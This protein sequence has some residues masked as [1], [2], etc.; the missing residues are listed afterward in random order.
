[1]KNLNNKHIFITGGS[2]GIGAASASLLAKY[3]AR[4]GVG[5][6]ASEVKAK[7]LVTSLEGEGHFVQSIDVS[8]E[9]SVRAAFAAVL[10]QFNGRLDGLVNSAGCT[11]DKVF[12]RISREDFFKVLNTNLYGSFLCAQA[13][14][15]AMLKARSGSV[16]NVSSIVGKLGNAGQANYAASKGGVES[17]T[18]SLAQEVGRRN[19]RVNCVRPGFIETPMTEK[20]SPEIKKLAADKSCLKRLGT[21]LEVAEAVCFLLSDAASYIT[22]TNLNV[23]GGRLL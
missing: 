9:Q 13:A 4:V 23:C 2:S 8:C 19:I 10:E 22:G 20:L 21:S 7:Q 5:F 16:V 14:I 12:L 3:G 17:L 1:M 11:V 6:C 18:L 15:K